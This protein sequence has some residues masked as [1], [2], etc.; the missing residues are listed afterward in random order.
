MLLETLHNDPESVIIYSCNLLDPEKNFR[1]LLKSDPRKVPR[2]LFLY[3]IC[4]LINNPFPKNIVAYRLMTNIPDLAITATE[5][6]CM[7]RIGETP[8]LI[9]PDPVYAVKE[10]EK[11]TE[12]E[13]IPGLRFRIQ[14]LG[15]TSAIYNEGVHIFEEVFQFDLDT[16]EVEAQNDTVFV[17]ALL[18]AGENEKRKTSDGGLTMFSNIVAEE[19]EDAEIIVN[20]NDPTFHSLAG[21]KPPEP[22][23]TE[24][25]EEPKKKSKSVIKIFK[26]APVL[27]KYIKEKSKRIIFKFK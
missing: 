3:D 5:L 2:K 23:K 20:E 9:Y 7:V 14:Q 4:G 11:I 15:L 25:A 1:M 16:L 21:M 22:E 6:G 24:A 18:H 27:K 10:L 12:R 19:M 8:E 26:S 13:H 17:E